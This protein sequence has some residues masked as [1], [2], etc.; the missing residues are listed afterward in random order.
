MTKCDFCTESA[1]NG[2]CFLSLQTVR[3]DYCEQAIKK[4][5]TVLKGSDNNG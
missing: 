1:P 3:E 4:M 2:K 5:V